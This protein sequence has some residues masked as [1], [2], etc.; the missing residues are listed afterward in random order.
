MEHLIELLE[1]HGR[2]QADNPTND[3]L[4]DSIVATRAKLLQY[5][6]DKEVNFS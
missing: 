2:L 6:K 4:W 1:M 3:Q 5:R